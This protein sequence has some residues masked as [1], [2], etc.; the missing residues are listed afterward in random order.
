MARKKT[1]TPVALKRENELTGMI[2]EVKGVH[3]FVQVE[4]GDFYCCKTFRGTVSENHDSTLAVVGDVVNIKPTNPGEGEE[5]GE[6]LIMRVIER[7][8]KLCRKRNRRTNR[9]G[10][11]EHVLASNI[12]QLIIVASA[13]M[14]PLRAGLIDRYLAYAESE[15]LEAIIVVNKIDL[16]DD[17]EAL[18]EELSGYQEIGYEVMFVSAVTGKGIGPLREK[19][20]GKTSVLSGH[21]GVGKSAL[22]NALMGSDELA[23]GEVSHKNLKGAHTTSNAIMMTIPGKKKK[24]ETSPRQGF[25]I[26]TPGIREFALSG[27]DKLDL[28]DCFV[29]FRKYTPDC[30]FATCTHTNEPNCAVIAAVEAEKIRVERYESYL[31][32]YDSLEESSF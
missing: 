3:F 19:L 6:G 4:D 16:E 14:P 29:E 10:E 11:A 27:I 22:I 15:N 20:M 28:R 12:D 24:G 9:S 18:H 1:E 30:G 32:L 31:A 5:I 26:D 8:M 2:V 13:T 23:T 25:V 21:S 7:R 17:M